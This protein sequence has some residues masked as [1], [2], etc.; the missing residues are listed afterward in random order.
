MYALARIFRGL[1][2]ALAVLLFIGWVRTYCASD[3]LSLEAIGQD[4]FGSISTG[5]ETGRGQVML[6]RTAIFGPNPNLA[7]RST[8]RYVASPAITVNPAANRFLTRA[9]NVALFCLFRYDTRR[10]PYPPH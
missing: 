8:F 4:T 7:P 1:S 3:R 9:F 5:I 2:I 6:F 10:T